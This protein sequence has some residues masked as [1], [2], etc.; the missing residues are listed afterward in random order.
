MIGEVSDLKPISE[1]NDESGDNLVRK[2]IQ[3]S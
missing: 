2:A 1:E 3:E